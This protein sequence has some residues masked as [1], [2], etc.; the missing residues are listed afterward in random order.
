MLPSTKLMMVIY[1]EN[2]AI[3]VLRLARRIFFSK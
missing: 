2:A 1:A 3:R